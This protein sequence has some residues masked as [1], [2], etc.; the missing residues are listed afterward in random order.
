M[1]N[2]KVKTRTL[3][4]PRHAA[5]P[6]YS[7]TKGLPPVCNEDGNNKV[8]GAQPEGCAT[9][10]ARL[11]AAKHAA[12]EFAFGLEPIVQITAWLFAAFEI[13]FVC[14]TSD[15]LITRRVPC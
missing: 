1:G 15:F 8:N 11:R 5:P 14:A 7:A 12:L 9:R 6:F 2:S 3:Q 13:D 4:K 10:L